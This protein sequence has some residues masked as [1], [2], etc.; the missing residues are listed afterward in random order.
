MRWPLSSTPMR[1][2]CVP[3]GWPNWVLG[4]HDRSRMANRIGSAQAREAA[5][6]LL[7][8]EG[9]ADDLSGRRN[10]HDQLADRVPSRTWPLGKECP[11]VW[12]GP[13]SRAHA[14][15]VGPPSVTPALR[16]A[17]PDSPL[18][19]AVEELNVRTQRS[20]P[21]STLSLYRGL[22]R[23]RRSDN[24]ITLGSYGLRSAT[25]H[26]LVYERRHF[27]GA[28]LVALN[29]TNEGAGAARPGPP[30]GK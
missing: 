19:P 1:P 4:N 25:Q 17:S 30:G 18:G 13:R 2:P 10:R 7:T 3:G 8:S 22:I 14:D 24:V 6:V 29:L 28:I 16:R 20:D 5:M 11:G 9:H 12:L 27:D 23:L 21:K 26:G 15:A